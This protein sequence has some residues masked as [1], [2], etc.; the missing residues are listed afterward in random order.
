M[1]ASIIRSQGFKNSFWSL[2]SASIYPVFIVIATPVLIHY[3]GVEQFGIWVLVNTFLQLISSFNLG[4]GDSTIKAIAENLAQQ[5]HTRIKKIVSNALSISMILVSVIAL[6]AI[7]FIELIKI[8]KTDLAIN[9][10]D[11]GI[12][13]LRFAVIIF[14][15]R[16]LEQLLLSILQGFNRYDISSVILVLSRVTILIVS[17]ICSVIGLG[18]VQIF[19]YSSIALSFILVFEVLY[20]KRIYPYLSFIPELSYNE[21]RSLLKFGIWTWLQG[22]LAVFTTQLDKFL[23]AS[24][25]GLNVLAY[26]S[27]G[28]MV[29]AQLHSLFYSASAWIFPSIV[30]KKIRNLPLIGLYHNAQWL[31]T[32]FGIVVI[33]A[34]LVGES[35]VFPLWLGEDMYAQSARFIRLFLY[36]N[37]FLIIN[38]IPF[39]FMNGSGHVR[40][41]TGFEFSLK[42]L[43]IF[44]MLSLYFLIG[45]TGL[46]WGLIISTALIT[47]IRLHKI[48]SQHNAKNVVIYS[49]LPVITMLMIIILFETSSKI[50]QFGIGS[51]TSIAY[52]YAYL[53]TIKRN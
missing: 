35:F 15:I 39:L 43:N 22:M 42:A 41:N 34:L 51:L 20:L 46:L 45:D 52:F 49:L 26:Y 47:P 29:T 1:F 19:L 53:S 40:Y 27:I 23:I 28:S 4:L 48:L 44:S 10:S 8:M 38:I 21:S 2:I 25:S 36:Y 37:L 12:I 5:Q 16:F 24:A 17:V 30:K 33:M 13:T 9:L 3:L 7:G 32:T 11:S 6:L 14:V 50:M 31:L 18:V